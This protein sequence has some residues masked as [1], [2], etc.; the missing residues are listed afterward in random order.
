MGFRRL[1]RTGLLVVPVLVL[2]LAGCTPN[3]SLVADAP[4]QPASEELSAALTGLLEETLGIAGATGA[5]AGVWSPWGGSWE[6]AV[7]WE[8]DERT[9]ALTTDAH[10]RLGTGGTE[11]MTCDVVVALAGSGRADLDA[12]IGETL[13]SLPGVD[14]LTLR[15][16]CAHT[17]GLADFRSSLWPTV[18][19][20]P[21]RQWPTLEL[22]AAAQ[23]HGASATPGAAWSDSST[24]PLLA[25]LVA[26]RI[27][28]RS[29]G[30]L[31][32]QY[33][34]SRYGLRSTELPGRSDVDLPAPSP[35]GYAVA[36]DL[37]TGERR[38]DLRLDV[39]AAS[40]SALGAAGGAVTDLE[41][42]RRLAAGL[43]ADPSGDAVW[44]D[45]VP[46][47][48][49]RADY[50]RAGLGGYEA[51]PLRGFSGLAPGFV[52]AAYSDPL[53]GLTVAVSINSST[54]GGDFAA[55]VA[56]ALAAIAVEQG[57]AAG[58]EGL[59][60]LPWTADG[61]RGAVQGT[62]ARC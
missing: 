55:T 51:G 50:L 16:L 58:A 53:S 1:T 60:Q 23:V 35:R 52:T 31:Y 59:P 44:Q 56:R 32:D 18:L 14:G 8:S 27:T 57:A 37:V 34:V 2:A 54:P 3:A 47:G 17:S 12:D 48:Q 15:Q 61:E 28:G 13:R 25:G 41:D 6:G 21:A 33:V 38:C 36:L 4:A 26:A 20:N 45:P 5:V 42:L 62:S 43:A 46:Q 19:Q 49:G 24:G 40:P 39:T 29:I 22:L 11:A 7:G 30:E 9:T 10:L